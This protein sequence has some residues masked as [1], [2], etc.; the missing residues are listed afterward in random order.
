MN[1]KTKLPKSKST[2]YSGFTLIEILLVTI[3]IGILA[4]VMIGV[5]NYDEFLGASRDSRRLANMNNLQTAMIGAIARNKILLTDTAGCASCDSI[6]GTTAVDGTG[7][8]QFDNISGNGLSDY[9]QALP[10]DPQN[11]GNLMFS[12][13][14]DGTDFELNVVLE[15]DRYGNLAGTDGGNDDTVYEKGWN[16]ELISP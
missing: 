6:S 3:I 2:K 14:S 15:S 11:S 10:L 7:W 1:A 16:L 12:Y 5:I 9:V 4:G 8:I 13:A